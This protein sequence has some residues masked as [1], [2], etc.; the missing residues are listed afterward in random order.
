MRSVL[1]LS[2]LVAL[3]GSANAGTVHRTHRQHAIAD[4][5]ARAIT[6]PMSSWGYAPPRAP[7]PYLAVPGDQRD[8]YVDSPYRNWGG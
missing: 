7:A 2:F 4:P 5:P 6:D 1:L 3:C 8:P